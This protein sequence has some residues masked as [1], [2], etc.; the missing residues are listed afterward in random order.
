MDVEN[1]LRINYEQARKECDYYKDKYFS[2]ER[3][4]QERIGNMEKEL[5]EVKQKLVRV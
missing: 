4:Y 3:R 1:K 2:C 5:M